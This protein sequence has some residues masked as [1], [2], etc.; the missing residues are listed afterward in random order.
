MTKSL[1]VHLDDD[2]K[3][4][5]TCKHLADQLMENIEYV[6]CSTSGEFF[7]LLK[8]RSSE[9]KCLIFDLFGENPG[10]NELND[11]K[12]PFLEDIKRSFTTFNVPIFIYSGFIEKISDE[13]LQEGTVFKIDKGDKG[14]GI[15]Q[16][17]QT[18]L[19]LEEA[20]FLNIFCNGGKIDKEIKNDLNSAFR[21][22]FI[23]NE[24]LLDVIKHI[25][26]S[27]KENL[28][29]RIE[30]VFKRVAFRS[31][32][33]SLLGPKTL[34]NGEIK[35]EYVNTI[36]HYVQRLND[37]PIWTGDIFKGKSDDNYLLVL[38]PRCDLA[39]NSDAPIL[40]CPLYL[41]KFPDF[42]KKLDEKKIGDVLTGNPA[43]S[44]YSRYIAPSPIFKGGQLRLKEY[45]IIARNDLLDNYFRVISLSDDLMNEISS[46]FSALFLRTGIASWSTHETKIF[47]DTK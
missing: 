17:F 7:D 27:N 33:T 20:G 2:A 29:D 30:Y 39:N 15:E 35:D 25:K 31:L 19:L 45:S 4:R 26:D 14:G 10:Q 24:Q 16:V 3:V 32:M 28:K 5:S 47:L 9:I 46:R 40:V 36:E 42:G 37:Y 41:G 44:G 6:Q 38:T 34:E 13:F 8:E 11:G 12:I 18:I 22:Q 23:N 21:K 43:V 1:V